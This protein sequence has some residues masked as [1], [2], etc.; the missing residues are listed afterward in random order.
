ML[1]IYGVVIRVA[2]QNLKTQVPQVIVGEVAT[3]TAI[4][5]QIL[6]ALRVQVGEVVVQT[7]VPQVLVVAQVRLVQAPQVQVVVLEKEAEVALAEV[8]QVGV[9]SI[10]M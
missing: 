2:V 7:V 5:A 1:T 4:Q 10:Y 9:G 6:Q 3:P 8:E